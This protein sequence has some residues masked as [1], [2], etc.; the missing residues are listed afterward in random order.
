[1]KHTANAITV[2]LDLFFKGLSLSKIV[3]HLQQF[4]DTDVS[5]TTVY[6]WIRK[7]VALMGSHLDRL[8]PRLS[9]RWHTDETWLKVGGRNEYMWNMLDAKTRFLIATQ[10]T[11]RRSGE[12][13]ERIVRQSVRRAGKKPNRW[14]TD[15]L[16]SYR[17]AENG[18]G[19]NAKTAH[20]SGNRLTENPNNNLIERFHGTVKER[21]KVMRG[22][23]NNKTAALFAKG[24]RI[25]YNFVRPHKALRGMTPAEAAGLR[26]RKTKN[27]WLGII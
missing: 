18:L 13:A 15:G 8:K 11:K 12:E 14:I 5:D 27:R 2:S 7:Y 20:I 17:Q 9:G 23:R 22:F 24:Y 4:H 6:R 3:D 21:T 26:R 19:G 25:Y 1:M 16:S 10:V